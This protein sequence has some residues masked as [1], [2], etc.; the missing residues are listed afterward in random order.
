MAPWGQSLER[1]KPSLEEP[2]YLARISSATEFQVS[3]WYSRPCLI[4]G[5]GWASRYLQ[6]TNR[7]YK[8]ECSWQ[9]STMLSNDGKWIQD[10]N[11]KLH[12]KLKNIFR[13]ENSLDTHSNQAVHE[14]LP[15]SCDASP[16]TVLQVPSSSDTSPRPLTHCQILALLKS[17]KWPFPKSVVLFMYGDLKVCPTK[18]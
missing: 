4:E 18:P 17:Q 5:W 9:N 3:P 10:C 7:I 1:L 15:T 2:R 11:E 6:R 16:N 14:F 8:H 13:L 12:D